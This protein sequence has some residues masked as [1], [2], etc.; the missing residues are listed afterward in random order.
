MSSVRG[1]RD[2]FRSYIPAW[3]QNRPPDSV[4][5]KARNVGYRWLYAMIFPLDVATQAIVEGLKASFPGVGTPTALAAIAQSR[6]L[7]QGESESDLAF[8]KRAINWLQSWSENDSYASEQMAR[9]IQAYLGNT[10]MVRVVDRAGHWLTLDSA[11][12]ATETTAAWNWDGV[13]NPERATIWSDLWII[14]YP[15]EWTQA[16]TFEVRKDSPRGAGDGVGVIGGQAMRTASD[17]ILSLVALRKGAHTRVVAIIFSYDPTLCV[18]G[19]SNNPD[20]TWGEWSKPFG[21]PTSPRAPS[22][23][24]NARYASTAHLF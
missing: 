16:P 20:G 22:R 14:I 15:C 6:G 1:F 5:G 3:L 11:G 4:T 10:P 8:A 12:N 19:G 13:S 2:S 21:D 18:P 17:A 9:E 7:T 23:S 24:A